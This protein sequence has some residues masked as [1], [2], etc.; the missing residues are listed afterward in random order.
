MQP[1]NT[2]LSQYA[3]HYNK[4]RHAPNPAPALFK[5]RR[6]NLILQLLS[7]LKPIPINY[8]NFVVIPCPTEGIIFVIVIAEQLGFPYADLS[9]RA[10]HAQW[11]DH[12]VHRCTDGGVLVAQQLHANSGISA[13]TMFVRYGTNI[14]QLYRY[15]QAE[16]GDIEN[17]NPTLTT[18][19]AWLRKQL[20]SSTMTN[21]TVQGNKTDV[22]NHPSYPQRTL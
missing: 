1:W 17:M 3:N 7:R 6:L 11:Q 13:D 22:R 18:M 4:T 15:N 9:S 21:Y 5:T 8:N 19:T 12:R 16:V 2:E 20:K 10:I 14:F